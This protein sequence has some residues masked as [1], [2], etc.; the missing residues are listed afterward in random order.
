MR[1]PSHNIFGQ[2]PNHW[3]AQC[4]QI[5]RFSKVLGEIF[6]FK[7]SPN[8]QWLLGYFEKHPFWDQNWFGNIL[9][10]FWKIWATFNFSIWSHWSSPKSKFLLKVGNGQKAIMNDQSIS[11][12]VVVVEWIISDDCSEEAIHRLSEPTI[13]SFHWPP[14]SR[15]RSLKTTE[16]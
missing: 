15:K 7:S 12:I 10:N 9:D 4:D 11:I 1:W 8:V 14:K 13:H 2:E 6:C 3:W 16:N 5:G